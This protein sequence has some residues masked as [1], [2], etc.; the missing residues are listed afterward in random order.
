[1]WFGGWPSGPAGAAAVVSVVAH[2]PREPDHY[3]RLVAKQRD[4][5]HVT[6]E[7]HRCR[8]DASVAA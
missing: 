2:D 4:L 8:D 7:V 1:M 6:I 5:V 3:K